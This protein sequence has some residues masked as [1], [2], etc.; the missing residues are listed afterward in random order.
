MDCIEL[1]TYT[2]TQ[3][4]GNFQILKLDEVL[5][6]Q[7]MI[8]K[9]H[10]HDFYFIL[11]IQKGKGTHTIDFKDY[12][13]VSNSIYFLRPGQIHELYLHK[14]TQGYLIT[15]D[16]DFYNSNTATSKQQFNALFGQNYYLLREESPKVYSLLHLLRE[17]H[18]TQKEGFK[19]AIIA[20]LE[21]F[22]LHIYREKIHS[23]DDMI[24]Q[25]YESKVMDAY[26]LLMEEFVCIHKKLPFY[27][28][29]LQVSLQQ[30]NTFSKRMLGKSSSELMVDQIILESKRVLLA[31]TLQVKEVA[32]YMGYEDVSYFIRFFKKHTNYTPK[33]FR[34]S[35][36]SSY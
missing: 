13:V 14:N 17:E 1:R 29:K 30:L 22:F 9:S 24:K 5:K 31:T 8:E 21:L 6:N 20:Y 28:E 25:S 26:L 18:T 16:K 3:G 11:V 12:K 19:Q 33:E 23:K 36:N 10:R 32:Y 15:F 27:T 2:N 34:E 7:E 4:L 35:Y